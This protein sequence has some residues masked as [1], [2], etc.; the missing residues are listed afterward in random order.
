MMAIIL[1]GYA[2]GFFL[3]HLSAV[4]KVPDFTGW[5]G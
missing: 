4:C 2:T 5:I 1:N 3:K